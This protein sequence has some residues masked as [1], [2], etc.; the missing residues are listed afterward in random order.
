[1]P[2]MDNWLYLMIDPLW[3]FLFLFFKVYLIVFIKCLLK[4]KQLFLSSLCQICLSL[5]QGFV[6][7]LEV[8]LRHF[9]LEVEWF[10]QVTVGQFVVWFINIF[11][12][13][14]LWFFLLHL[15]NFLWFGR[16]GI[17]RF[18]NNPF[19]FFK[20]NIFLIFMNPIPLLLNLNYQLIQLVNSLLML[21]YTIIAIQYL[22][23]IKSNGLTWRN[24]VHL[25]Y[26]QRSSHWLGNWICYFV[27]IAQ[28]SY[29]RLSFV[30][31]V[32]WDVVLNYIFSWLQSW[33]YLLF[34]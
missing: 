33:I 31:L 26:T 1:M 24:A 7:K 12:F 25:S 23:L 13:L 16:R 17:T 2:C 5:S 8:E 30:F 28:L 6:K 4:F 10:L 11:N 32:F 18:L 21:S 29:L 15:N 3:Y 22:W 27:D 20:N 9:L 34:N 19:N 14:W